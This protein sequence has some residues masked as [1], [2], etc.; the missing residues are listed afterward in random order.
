MS[1]FKKNS[2]FD[3]YMHDAPS[4]FSF[5]I[6][7]KISDDG[8]R[9][10]ER[11]WRSASSTQQSLIV[12]LSYVTQV[13]EAARK[14]LRGWY[15]AGAELVANRNPAKEIVA[16][17]TGLPLEAVAAAAQ[18]HTWRPVAVAMALAI[19]SSPAPQIVA[20]LLN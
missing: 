3:F 2:D 20:R 1:S 19:L 6:S 10:L 13:D 16:S 18:S 4:A 9:E 15:D 12:D 14:L 7:G 5:E 11:A 8:A 17:I